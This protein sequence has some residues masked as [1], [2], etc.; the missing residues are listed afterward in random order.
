MRAAAWNS[1]DCATR[2]SNS[3]YPADGSGCLPLSP[4]SSAFS[5]SE[6]R[7][8]TTTCGTPKI[9]HLRRLRVATRLYHR[10]MI[11]K[12]YAARRRAVTSHFARPAFRQ[13]AA[14]LENSNLS[15]FTPL[16][17]AHERLGIFAFIRIPVPRT[18]QRGIGRAARVGWSLSR[19]P[20]L[21][22]ESSAV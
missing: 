21:P 1:A 19:R 13:N 12:A 6:I 15:P 3:T 20:F 16:V 14:E 10:A 17:P 9:R 11:E 5:P 18:P 8:I 4:A 7:S 2:V 22:R